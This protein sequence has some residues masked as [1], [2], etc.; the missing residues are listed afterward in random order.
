M[1]KSSLT[2][3][4]L[5]IMRI[6]FLLWFAC[7]ISVSANTFSQKFS[8]NTENNTTL[9]KDILAEIEATS[10]YKFLY[11]TDLINVTRQISLNVEDADIVT[12]MSKIFDPDQTTYRIFDD[13]LIVI[14]NK[15]N[16]Q[17]QRITGSVIDAATGEPLPGVN[18]RVKGTTIGTTT[19]IEGKFNIDIPNPSSTLEFTFIGFRQESIQVAGLSI[20]NVRLSPDIQ[21]LEEVVVV[22]YGTQKKVSLTGA[23]SSVN[24][25]KLEAISTTNL[26]T[27]LAGRVP[28]VTISSNSGFVGASADILMRGKG[29]Y[30][31]TAPLYVID[32]II[33]DKT[34]FDVLDPNEVEGISFLKDAASAS[35]YGSRAASGVVLVTTKKGVVQKPIFGF[36]TSYTLQ[37]PT[38]PIQSYTSLEQLTYLNDNAV[39]YGNPKPYGQEIFDYFKDKNYQLMDYLWRDPTAKQYD[40]SVNGGSESLTYYMMVGMNKAKGSFHNTDYSRYNFRS[41]VTAKINKYL[42]L[43]FNLSGNQRSGERFYWPYDAAESVTLQDFYRATFNWS[44]LT[45]FYT[46]ADGTPTTDR[47]KGYPLISNWHPIELIYNGGYRK[48]QYRTLNGIIRADVK[49]PFIEGLTTSFVANYTVDD[50][51]GK[52]YIKHVRGYQ[53]QKASTT[54][55]FIPGPIN[56]ATLTSHNLSNSYE[57]IQENAAF[58][59]SYQLNGFLNYDRVF[60]K[61][62]VSGLLVYEQQGYSGKNFNGQANELLSSDLD[63]IISA[64]RAN[65]KRWFDGTESE[66]AR[67]SWIGRLHYEYAGKYIAEF[68]GRY[69]G[70]YIFP[71]D[72]RWGFFPSISAAWRISEESFFNVPL[73]SNLK[74]RTSVGTS[75]N[76][77]VSPFQFQTNYIL[78]NSYAF[79][80]GLMTGIKAGTPPNLLITWEKS[81]NYDVG[82]DFGLFNNKLTGELDYFYR[83]SYDILK[84]RIR[85]IPATYGASLSSENYAEMDVRG[86]EFII[87]YIGNIGDFNY[88]VGGN[89]GWAKDKVLYIDEAAALEPWRSAIGQPLDR[90]WGYEDFGL[91]RNQKT[92]DALPA[93]FTQF[94]QIPTLGAILFKDI[95]GPNRSE[96]A[97]GKI[98]S[99][100]QTWLSTN[101][102]PR[103]N[104]GIN[105]DGDWKG[106]TLSV[107]FQGVGGYDKM[108]RTMNTST[109][110]VFQTGGSPY[111][112]LWVDHWSPENPNAKYPRSA[113]WGASQ[114][115]WEPSTF[116]MRNGA[117]LR[118]KNLNLAY[119]LPKEW[120]KYLL[121]D[122]LQI[123][124][125]GTN[126]FVI[127]E[128]KETDPEQ[129]MLDSY[130]MM[131]SFTAG[132]S[133]NF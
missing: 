108:V 38:K 44:R 81:T 9:I 80:S 100:D 94:G 113:G 21:A 86:L 46:L 67:A 32:G 2:K 1:K 77:N 59:T 37:T 50:Y 121:I 109:G 107:L 63:Q 6:S 12:I 30:N 76:D 25:S 8:V 83:Y 13:S 97:D 7:L 130:P 96:G 16:L 45:P 88:T 24:A 106:I 111:F 112:E 125:N 47:T 11:R 27:T 52:N 66:N 4:N 101:A 64:S 57:N 78:G 93:G 65:D 35:I 92:L 75:G 74:L 119:S 84:D 15:N 133:I 132:L 23:I 62:T 131:K 71:A 17:Q 70:S 87:N 51:N 129:Y 110:G 98:D 49:I 116:W 82:L 90:L 29:T 54:N 91:I 114:Y 102:I 69:D 39:T 123:Y 14:T 56:F 127:S 126:L 104:Y 40:L 79:G 128:F 122:N 22:G 41:N 61:N 58:G 118:L 34:D 3:K 72:T 95:R 120:V 117:Y 115:G 33:S 53:M 68:S 42:S 89:V 85:V 5:Q 36:K 10:N 60:G 105:L 19:D 31:N 73:I 48:T 28:G 103:I 99:N 26:S 124:I 18:V 55:P 20:I 43:N